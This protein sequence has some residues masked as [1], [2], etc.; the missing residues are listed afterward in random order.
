M[1]V[2]EVRERMC[3]SVL[4]DCEVRFILVCWGCLMLL[5]I[6]QLRFFDSGKDLEIHTEKSTCYLLLYNNC[7]FSGVINMDGC[8]I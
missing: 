7:L 2:C 8:Y 6:G 5:M 1:C 3:V 4:N